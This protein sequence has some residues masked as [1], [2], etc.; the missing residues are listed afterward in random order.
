[1]AGPRIAELRAYPFDI[2]VI[3]LI[4]DGNSLLPRGASVGHVA[5]REA[6]VGELGVGGIADAGEQDLLVVSEPESRSVRRTT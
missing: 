1:M 6:A 4:Q 5:R 3:D 2:W